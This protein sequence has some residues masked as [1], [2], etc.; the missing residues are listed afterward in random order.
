MVFYLLHIN[1]KIDIGLDKS[2]TKFISVSVYN[3]CKTT[4]TTTSTDKIH[5]NSLTPQSLSHS[6]IR[7]VPVRPSSVEQDAANQPAPS[8]ATEPLSRVSQPETGLNPPEF[9]HSTAESIY[10]IYKFYVVL[11]IDKIKIVWDQNP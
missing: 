2:L 6:V 9:R 7:I 10:Y 3:K 1:A 11:S 4:P 5:S 8:A